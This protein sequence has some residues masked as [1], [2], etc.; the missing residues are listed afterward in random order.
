MKT[1]KAI[2]SYIGL[3]ILGGAFASIV[4]AAGT[5]AVHRAQEIRRNFALT[6]AQVEKLCSAALTHELRRWCFEA[7]DREVPAEVSC[8][9]KPSRGD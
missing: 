2:L 3:C 4:V 9:E 7:H 6:D 5:M 1:V 8:E